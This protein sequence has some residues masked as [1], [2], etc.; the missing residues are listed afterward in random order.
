MLSCLGQSEGGGHGH[1][2]LFKFKDGGRGGGGDRPKT[3]VVGEEGGVGCNAER[4]RDFAGQ[5]KSLTD[6]LL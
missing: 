3:A 4:D 5:A 6:L 2:F 1:I